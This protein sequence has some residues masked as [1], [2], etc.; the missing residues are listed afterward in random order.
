MKYLTLLKCYGCDETL[1]EEELVL[2][3]EFEGLCVKCF[4]ES[5]DVYED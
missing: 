1:C 3:D 4:D 5:Q 2:Y